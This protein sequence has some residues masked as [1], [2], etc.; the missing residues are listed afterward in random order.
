MS[1]ARTPQLFTR[2]VV[3]GWEAAQ[4]GTGVNLPGDSE[5]YASEESALAWCDGMLY[6]WQAALDDPEVRSD[7]H[8]E[9][10]TA[11]RREVLD[12]LT[13]LLEDDGLWRPANNGSSKR[14]W[15]LIRDESVP[16]ADRY[17]LNGAGNL[18]R[19]GSHE[20]AVKAAAKLNANGPVPLSERLA[21]KL[22]ALRQER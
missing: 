20:A 5:R 4:R 1:E 17:H 19:F 14:R 21:A 18:V 3:G 13:R 6:G 9:G 12:I 15:F 16:L 22:T 8:G 11:G 2:P 10:R 7:I